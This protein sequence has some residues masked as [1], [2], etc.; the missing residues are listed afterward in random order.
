[1][2]PS[3]NGDWM[4]RVSMMRSVVLAAYEGSQFIGTQLDSIV[5]QLARDDEVIVSDDASRDETVEIVAGRNDPRI[6][7]L[8]NPRRL[9]YVKNFERAIAS[10]RGEYIVFSDQD[11]VWLPNKLSAVCAALERT[12][13]VVSDAIVVD[14]SLR[15]LHASYFQLRQVTSFTFTSTF[16][17]PC[18]I[19]ATMA[20]RRSYLETL[21][22][23]PS[24]V[25]HD[26]WISLNAAWEGNLEIIRDPLILYRRHPSTASVSATAAKRQATTILRE[27][28]AM[29]KYLFVRRCGSLARRLLY[30]GR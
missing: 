2:P 28:L 16:V 18:F 15:E 9:G 13:C 1:M 25:P 20:C 19:G 7:V 17:K 24:G 12:P 11:D 6:R 29:A 3:Q 21:M 4:R 10:A 27:R 26:F 8:R 22:P 23:F 30:S 14:E 5:A